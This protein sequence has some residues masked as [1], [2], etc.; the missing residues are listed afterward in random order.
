M[1]LQAI[2]IEEDSIRF[3]DGSVYKGTW[4]ALGMEGVGRY[5]GP[6]HAILEGQFRDGTFHGHGTTYWPRG[7]RLDG[8]WS[9][10]ECKEKRYTFNDGLIFHETDW[11]YCKFP[12]RRFQTCLLYGLRPAGATLRTNYPHDIMIP[13]MCY[14]AGI[15]IFDPRTRCIVSYRDPDKVLEIPTVAMAQWIEKNCRKGWTEPTGHREDLYENWFPKDADAPIFP[16]TLLPFSNDSSECWWKRLTTFARDDLQGSETPCAFSCI[17]DS[18]ICN[19][20]DNCE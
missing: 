10:G 2:D 12:D 13:P 11:K 15:G 9:H 17:G 3:I 19:T 14:D 7:Q 1:D 8:V 6:H 5:I 18:V 20:G 4:N 16:P